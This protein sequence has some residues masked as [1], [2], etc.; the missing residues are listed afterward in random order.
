MDGLL[1][2]WGDDDDDDDRL[3]SGVRLMMAMAIFY[4]LS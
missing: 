1:I 2:C 4:L 3:Q